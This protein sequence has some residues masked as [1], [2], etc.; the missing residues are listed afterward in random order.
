MLQFVILFTK[1]TPL[2]MHI[3]TSRGA[4]IAIMC[5]SPLIIPSES[6]FFLLNGKNFPHCDNLALRIVSLLVAIRPSSEQIVL[7]T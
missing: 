5:S 1:L 2:L 7:R 3:L 4:R 6:Y